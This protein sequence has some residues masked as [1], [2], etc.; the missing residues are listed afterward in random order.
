VILFLFIETEYN[1]G[2]VSSAAPNNPAFFH[3]CTTNRSD[4]LRAP[5]GCCFAHEAL[6][7]PSKQTNKTP[8]IL[9]K[10]RQLTAATNGGL[11]HHNTMN[12]RKL[13]QPQRF[14]HNLQSSDSSSDQVGRVTQAAEWP[15]RSK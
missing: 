10:T 8:Q 11:A 1:T 7:L 9:P 2:L 6:V 12:P 14:C 4:T 5:E 13:E 15:S 3:A